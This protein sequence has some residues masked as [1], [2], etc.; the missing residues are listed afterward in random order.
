MS[1]RR[2][3]AYIRVSQVD[4]NPDNQKRAI[5]EWAERNNVDVIGF[6]V[7]VDV[8]GG[9][10]PR[11]RPKY[12]AMIEFAKDSG[13]NM[14]LFYD[15]SRLSRSLEDGLLELRKLVEEGF[16]FKFVAQEFLDYIEDPMLRKKVISDFLWF[17]ELYRKDVA[18]RTAE[19][20]RRLMLENKVYYRPRLIHY[21][22]LWLSGKERF[23]QLTPEDI[24]KA[25]KYVRDVIGKYME[26]KLP[27]TRIREIL[28]K[29]LE[30]LYEKYGKA[31]K[32]MEAIKKLLVD[33]E[34][35]KR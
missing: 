15:L 13:I 26:V 23:V 34:L 22:A 18:R 24:E 11:E 25:K 35:L 6:F 5:L 17:A 12:R 28:L 29:Q 4:E 19:A 2:A 1:A 3:V 16:E 27:L 32:S 33:S 20:L 30:P 10:P 9:V 21:I 8:S 14:I 7:D 31:P